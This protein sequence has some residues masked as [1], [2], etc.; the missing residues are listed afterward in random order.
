MKDPGLSEASRHQLPGAALM[1]VVVL[2][3]A[4]LA[5]GFLGSGS[6][7]T[8][9]RVAVVKHLPPLTRTPLP[10]LSPTPATSPNSAALLAPEPDLIAPTATPVL[11]PTFTAAS[12]DR[13]VSTSSGPQAN[14]EPTLTALVN[15]NVRAGPGADYPVLGS[16]TPG[17]S[18][19]INGK[20]PEGTW[21][22]IVYPSSSGSLAWVS[23]DTEYSTSSSVGAVPIAQ[24]PPT[25]PPTDIPTDTPTL[26]PTATLPPLQTPA[27]ETVVPTTTLASLTPVPTGDATA[28][29]TVTSVSVAAPP[30]WAF[31]SVR[32]YPDDDN[33]LLYGNAINNTG[34]LQTIESITGAFYDKNGKTISDDEEVYS[35][36]PVNDVPPGSSVPFELVAENLDDDVVDFKLNAEAEPGH[37]S[38]RQDFQFADVKQWTERDA[39]CVSGA[40]QDAGDLNDYL[41]VAVILYDA[42]DNMVKFSDSGVFDAGDGIGEKN[43]PFEICVDPPNQD[44]ARYE[45][46]AWGR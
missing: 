32:F 8:S 24:L 10:T 6:L 43:S 11:A 41:V 15:L 17:Q 22:Q 40:V 12:S 16:L 33:L 29:P 5:C 3:V 31:A 38:P 42:Q 30:G 46:E 14:N 1:V 21:W 44:V 2:A 28:E 19:Q 4:S 7:S 34:S 26:V 25:P 23:A 45:V 35:Y 20:N 36:W 27:S 37:E 9:D 39:Y 18:F 13:L